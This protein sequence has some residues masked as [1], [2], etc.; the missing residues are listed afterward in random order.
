[1]PEDDL[2]IQ[3]W[4]S[5]PPADR[6]EDQVIA[7]TTARQ[8][9]GRQRPRIALNLTAMIDVTF[10]LLVYFMVATE[11]KTDEEIYRL[12]LPQ[13][14]QSDQQLDPFELDRQPL[15][16]VVASTGISDAS[17]RVRLEGPYQQPETFDDLHAFLVQM[18]I[19]DVDPSGLFEI[20]HPII[21]QPARSATWEHTID[22]FNA[23]AR[24]RYTNIQ[25]AKPQ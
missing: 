9:H 7:H 24:A 16:I 6:E 15:R 12:D 4:L 3:R 1:M 22:A 21:I 25:F 8:R 2:D 23:A 14:L 11:F 19:N 18:Q 13:K 10:L 5:R 17:Y 20:D